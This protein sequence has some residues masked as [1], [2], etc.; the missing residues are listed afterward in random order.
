[1]TPSQI[2]WAFFAGVVLTVVILAVQTVSAAGVPVAHMMF[3]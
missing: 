1:M 2:A 3:H